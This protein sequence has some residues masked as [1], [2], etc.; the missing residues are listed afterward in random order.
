MKSKT[1]FL[2]FCSIF[3]LTII[4]NICHSQVT[5]DSSRYY[6]S[7][8]LKPENSND[9]TDAYVFFEKHKKQS[10]IKKD[11]LRAI[12]DLRYISEVQNKLGSLYDSEN[13]IV[14]AMDYLENLNGADTLIEPRIGIYNQL[15][16][17]YR[18][19]EDYEKSIYYYSKC[20]ELVKDSN[21][22]ASVT[23]NIA[24]VYREQKKYELAINEFQEVYKFYTKQGNI[25]KAARAIDN[26]GVV[27]SKINNSNAIIN[28]EKALNMRISI[29]HVSG[30]FTS[31]IHLAEYYKETNNYNKALFYA[32]KALII[33]NSSS[34][35]KYKENVLSILLDLK[36]DDEVREYKA[37]MDSI[38]KSKQ[39]QENKYAASKYE[40]SQYLKKAQESELQREKEKRL[41][42]IYKFIGLLIILLAIS[43]Y[44]ILKSRHKKDKIKQVY[45]TEN[46]ISKK[47]HDEVAN[48]VYQ[49]M[50]KL[51]GS[52]DI[53]EQILDDLESLYTRVRDISKENGTIDVN[54]HYEILLNDLLLS[55]K[56]D[57]VNI[58]TR[59]IPKIDWNSVEALKKITLY[60]VLQELMVNMKK[61]SQATNV[62]LT[63]NTSNNKIAINYTDNGIG[64]KIKKGSGL[65]NM[66]N[67]IKSIKGTIIFESEI[68]NGFKVKITV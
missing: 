15:G 24:N 2:F 13:S 21:H 5:V 29:N 19:F 50:S 3:L 9:L 16:I 62:A 52:K 58:I 51:Q 41:K 22:I 53:K 67:R 47:V 56:N 65:L 60:R 20:L 8:I 32:E 45:I 63:F 23:N 4:S 48:D 35:K 44:I 59:G 34:N 27:L 64:C 11:T 43:L 25:L 28:L 49:V 68:N 12:L 57:H 61:H 33:A 1:S 36:D 46:R 14:L 42:I 54:D 6:Y 38:N 7:L 26:I 30:V 17:L 18:Q 37:L 31:Y 40:Y 39:I 55:Y 10:L 66:G